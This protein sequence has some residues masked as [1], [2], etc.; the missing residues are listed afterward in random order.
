[1]AHFRGEVVGARGYA[2]RL[3]HKNTG[4][5]L[6]AQTWGYDIEISVF[7][8]R[9]RKIDI[10]VIYLVNHKTHEVGNALAAVNLTTGDL[11]GK[12]EE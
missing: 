4:L 5:K 1:M 11:M 9:R 6:L 10:G 2:S 7:H 3:G 12:E 8:D